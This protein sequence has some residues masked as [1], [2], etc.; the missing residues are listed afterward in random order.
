MLAVSICP[1][2]ASLPVLSIKIS[3]GLNVSIKLRIDSVPGQ[4]LV[5]P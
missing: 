1:V 3:N 2:I 4:G 5:K